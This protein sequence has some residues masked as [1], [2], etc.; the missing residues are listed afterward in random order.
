[1]HTD[2]IAAAIPVFFALMAVEIAASRVTK[3]RYYRLSDSISDLA[4]GVVQ[5]V[6]SVFFR[7]L[8]GAGYLY[9][10]SQHRLAAISERSIGAWIALFF[11][12]DFFYYWFHRTSHEV[13]LLWGAHV[14]HHQSEEYNLA[15]ALRQ[16]AFQPLFSWIFYLPLAVI[17]F[18][19]IMFYTMLSLST[20]Y[21]FWI[22]T[23]FIPKL[24]PLEWFLNTPSHHR[25]HHGRNPRYIDRNH[26]A[27]L[28]IWDRMFGTF[29]EESEP[30]VFGVTEPLQS[31]NPIWANFHYYRDLLEDARRARRFSDKLKIWFMTPGWR[32]EAGAPLR[33]R[34]ITLDAPKYGPR[35]R[36]G[37]AIYGV[38]QFAIAVLATVALL[39]L[40]G[41]VSSLWEL[42]P[43][44]ALIVLTCLVVGGLF[45]DKS[46]AKRVEP[47]RVLL[48][49]AAIGIYVFG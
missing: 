47:A 12:V 36:R 15:V 37:L 7:V 30:V 8:I 20:L 28:I 29:E 3:R 31:W 38:A 10:Y 18:P 44:G 17:G 16:A 27:T 4:C 35:S 6:S 40:R 23:R 46:W 22:H 43:L 26:G 33:E 1:M 5:Q 14:V 13:N 48:V 42:A 9:L 41:E 21:Q 32:P 19:P 11:G 25:V 49:A 24:G 2:Y 39:Q 45:E 34:S